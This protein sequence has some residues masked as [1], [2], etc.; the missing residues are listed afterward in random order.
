MDGGAS[1][2]WKQSADL[3]AS[4]RARLNEAASLSD[5][6]AVHRMLREAWFHLARADALAY[7]EE[8]PSSSE[9]C[10]FNPQH[11]PA[12]TEVAW[13]PPGDQPEPV[14]ACR[15]D[16]ERIAAGLAPRLRRLRLT[17]FTDQTGT[18]P[19]QRHM[20]LHARGGG[21]YA[22][23]ALYSGA[24][25]PPVDLSSGPTRGEQ[26]V[27]PLHGA[28]AGVAVPVGREG[29]VELG[30]AG[31]VVGEGAVD[32]DG[33]AV[34]ALEEVAER[35]AVRRTAGPGARA[36]SAIDVGDPVAEQGSRTCASS[37]HSGGGCAP[38]GGGGA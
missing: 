11:G 34:G 19:I 5:V 22:L 36:V 3:M 24:T 4:A 38:G 27:L 21:G 14:A 8:P 13:A 25:A 20:E 10:F 28:V 18:S 33:R 26:Q 16:A 30:R 31:R 12:T 29:L 7:D 1:A 17:A 32:R 15:D 6:L 9:P 37:P 2:E 23:G 35:R